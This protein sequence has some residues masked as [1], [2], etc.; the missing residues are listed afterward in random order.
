MTWPF[1]TTFR[2]FPYRTTLSGPALPPDVPLGCDSFL[3]L[4]FSGSVI[5][6]TFQLTHLNQPLVANDSPPTGSI[7]P[8]PLWRR[9]G[10]FADHVFQARKSWHNPFPPDVAVLRVRFRR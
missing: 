7:P 8:P 5:T 4:I 10:A 1:L 6:E 3:L 9:P 2:L